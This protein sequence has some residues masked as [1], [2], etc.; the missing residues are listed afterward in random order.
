MKILSSW[1]ERAAERAQSELVAREADAG[2]CTAIANALGIVGCRTFSARYSI[3]PLDCGR[4]LVAGAFSAVLIQTCVV[5]LEPF[6][7]SIEE[8]FEIEFWPPD[9]LADEFGGET[10]HEIEIDGLAGEDPEPVVNG[11][12]QIGPVLYELLAAATDPF[13]RHPDAELE[14]TEAG[15]SDTELPQHPFA[16]LRSLKPDDNGA[17]DE[18]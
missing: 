4:Y 6:D 7:Q 10:A 11:R 16:A 9:Q 18:D 8:S 1:T 14:R 12:L 15:A 3:S 2:E 13:P 5:T 17:G